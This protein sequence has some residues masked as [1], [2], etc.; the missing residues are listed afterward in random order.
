MTREAGIFSLKLMLDKA[1]MGQS[2]GF[3]ASV[4]KE[5]V[6]FNIRMVNEKGVPDSYSLSLTQ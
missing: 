6:I 1:V 5:E 3:L 2:S 4:K